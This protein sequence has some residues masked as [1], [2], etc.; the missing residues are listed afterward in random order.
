MAN[1]F[2]G[3]TPIFRVEN[4][5]ASIEYYMTVLGFRH[6]WGGPEV[7]ASVSR[8]RCQIFL[9]ERDQRHPGTWTW[10]PVEA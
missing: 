10:P 6:D 7:F 4:L 1:E 3:A 2:R 8:G 9:C 5:R